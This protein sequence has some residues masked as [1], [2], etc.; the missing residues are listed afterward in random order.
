MIFLPQFYDLLGLQSRHGKHTNLIK[1][2]EK[3][4]LDLELRRNLHLSERGPKS[5][6]S[7]ALEAR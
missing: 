7:D 2:S 1:I 4:S 6:A 3:T 5:L